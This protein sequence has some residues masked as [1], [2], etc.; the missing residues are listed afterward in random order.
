MGKPSRR[1]TPSA[2][3]SAQLN[4]QKEGAARQQPKFKSHKA[5]RGTTNAVLVRAAKAGGSLVA[6]VNTTTAAGAAA[7][8]TGEPEQENGPRYASY[9]VLL[10]AQHVCAILCGVCSAACHL[11][12]SQCRCLLFLYPSGAGNSNSSAANVTPRSWKC[13]A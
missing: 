8:A 6:R 9:C 13:I 12:Q 10:T 7:A 2:K 1:R 4:N 3:A 11:D 5:S